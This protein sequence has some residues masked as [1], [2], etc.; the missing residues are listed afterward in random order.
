MEPIANALKSAEHWLDARGRK[1]WIIAVVLGFIFVW[2][3]GLAL[4][5]YAIWSNRMF[6]STHKSRSCDR[7]AARTRFES[8]GNDAFDSYRDETLKR[9]ED[10]Q[11]AF[12]TF[13]DKLRRAKDQAEFD[14]FM[15]DRRRRPTRDAD[16]EDAEPVNERRDMDGGQALYPA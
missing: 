15:D 16:V 7:R 4:L 13:L 2:P 8:S 14:Q 11:A 12:Q 6:T 3:I 10:E 9:L 5:M 1:A